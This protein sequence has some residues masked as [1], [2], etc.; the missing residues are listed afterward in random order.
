[1]IG[2]ELLQHNIDNVKMI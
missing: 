2:L 1:L